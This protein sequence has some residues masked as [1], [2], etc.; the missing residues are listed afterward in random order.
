MRR[1]G[2]AEGGQTLELVGGVDALVGQAEAEPDRVG[3]EARPLPESAW[4]DGR[5]NTRSAR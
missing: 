1:L 4:K 5:V 3:A 2:A